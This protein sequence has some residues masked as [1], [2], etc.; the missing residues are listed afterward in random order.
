MSGRM[1]L[2][3]VHCRVTIKYY[4]INVWEDGTVHCRVTIK[5]YDINVWK[6]GTLIQTS[7]GNP[8]HIIAISHLV[9]AYTVHI[10]EIFV[11]CGFHD[12]DIL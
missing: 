4:D 12:T 6:D 7:G 2:Y 8:T 9:Q 3:T 10:L 5:Y 11:T 1:A